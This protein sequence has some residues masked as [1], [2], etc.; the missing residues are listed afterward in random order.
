MGWEFAALWLDDPDVQWHWVWRRVA[1]DNG[2]LLEQSPPFRDL[3]TCISDAKQH[4]F[5]LD[6]CVLYDPH[7]PNGG[8]TP[9]Q[10]TW[11]GYA[12]ILSPGQTI[13]EEFDF[14]PGN[15]LVVSYVFGRV[16]IHAATGRW[17]Q[18]LLLA[19]KNRSETVAL[20]LGALFWS[21]VLAL[22]YVWPLLVAGLVVASL[23]LALTARSRV[24]WKRA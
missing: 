11:V 5:D 17:L 12:A 18:R 14:E 2:S 10:L 8:L 20:F 15:Y 22:P 3:D 1:D 19:E 13:W 6:D 16:V 9:D 7:K 23:G 21:V 24:G 4:G